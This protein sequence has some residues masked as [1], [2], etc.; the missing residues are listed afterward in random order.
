[1]NTRGSP[2]GRGGWVAASI[3]TGLTVALVIW[4]SGPQWAA[5]PVGGFAAPGWAPIWVIAA[6]S[7]VA[8]AWLV[9]P[10]QPAR[11]WAT[12]AATAGWLAPL[13]AAVP[14]TNCGLSVLVLSIACL[15]PTGVVALHTSAGAPARLG[16]VPAAFGVALAAVALRAVTIDPLTDPA[17][18]RICVAGPG[19]LGAMD[20]QLGRRAV[21]VLVTVAAVLAFRGVLADRARVRDGHILRAGAA[22]VIALTPWWVPW[23]AAGPRTEDVAALALALA[24]VLI[25]V[26][27]ARLLRIRRAARNMHDAM[28]ASAELTP[29]NDQVARELSPAQR[30]AVDNA[31]LTAAARAHSEELLASRRRI[32]HAFDAERERLGRDLHDIVQQRA[33]G[34]LI[35]MQVARAQTPDAQRASVLDDAIGEVSRCLEHL[36]TVGGR[37]SSPLVESDGLGPAVQQRAADAGLSR[38]V[39]TGETGLALPP[40]R[41]REIYTVLDALLETSLKNPGES[42]LTIDIQTH[43]VVVVIRGPEVGL[44][45]PVL[46]RVGAAEGECSIRMDA[47]DHP[48]VEVR[49][50]CES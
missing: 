45:E 47:D 4:A 6:A 46:D 41:S 9:G 27:R 11:G 39:A 19:L 26:E 34:A 23:N 24:C 48:E 22:G 35:G 38:V 7:T 28:L 15:V 14:G 2:W 33:V 37:S 10:E 12:T 32:V 36:R 3:T 29:L 49:F 16:P 50:R 13:V 30:L 31:R 40:D 17:C 25:V 43:Q 8:V 5:S 21:A 44:P 20:P 42:T 18:T 1:M